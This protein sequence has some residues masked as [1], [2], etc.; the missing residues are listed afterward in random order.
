MKT[1]IMKGM[2]SDGLSNDIIPVA[3]LTSFWR[4][5]VAPTSA[6]AGKPRCRVSKQEQ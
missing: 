5:K 6:K 2:Q 3:C 1:M 4:F